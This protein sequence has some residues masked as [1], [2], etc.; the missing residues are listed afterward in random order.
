[1]LKLSVDK[2]RQE[3]E[4]QGSL[5]DL[6]NDALNAVGIMSNELEKAG[7]VKTAGLF[8][9]GIPHAIITYRNNKNKEEQHENN[10]V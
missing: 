6:L 7:G 5:M 10:V 9:A 8:I 1:M 2:S 4:M 3:I